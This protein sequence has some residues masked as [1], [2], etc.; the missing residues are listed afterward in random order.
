MHKYSFRELYMDKKT[1]DY[2]KEEIREN[3]IIEFLCSVSDKPLLSI[4]Q[5]IEMLKKMFKRHF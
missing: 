4:K 3:C 2:S 1:T 5:L